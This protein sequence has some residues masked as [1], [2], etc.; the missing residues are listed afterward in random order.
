MTP[1]ARVA[2]GLKGGRCNSD[3]IDNS[4]GV[5]TSDVEVNI[6]IALAPAVR[7]G[8][9]SAPKRL[10]LLKAMTD[11]VAELVLRNNYQQTL[12]ISL[13]QKRGL[14][15]LGNQIRLMGE[16]EERGLLDRE[17]ENIPTDSAL[18]A[19]AAG[20][21]GLTRSEIG[22]LLAFAKIALSNDLVGSAVPDDSYLGREL[23]RYFPEEMQKRHAAGIE[24][25]RLRREIIATQLANSLVN[26]GGPT[27][28]VAARD[29]SGASVAELTRAYAAVRDSFALQTLHAEIDALDAAISGR[30][31]LELY[32]TVQDVLVDRMSWFIRNI[33]P[34]AGLEDIVAHYS[35]AFDALADVLPALL[36]REQT[37][38][39]REL[40]QRLKSGGVPESLAQRITLLPQLAHAASVV[41][42]ADRTGRTLADAAKAYF[43]VSDRFGFA[44]IDR[45]TE[46]IVSGDY[47]E[48]LALKKARD[49]LETAHR[50][51]AQ[52]VIANG[53][54]GDV[55][56]WEAVVGERVAAT[57]E[58]V[59][60]ILSDR[61]PSMAKVTVAASLL[62]ELARG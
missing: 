54:G 4:A 55:A 11:E 38:A 39:M 12:A 17:V 18:E 8:K 6:K 34:T 51:L 52:H 26:R 42:I 19:R 10:A 53:S 33:D 35:A 44:R 2:Y 57:A 41:P 62:S 24:G 21:R 14:D 37:K 1:K 20:G 58:Q 5:N 49:S 23:F 29:R 43:A 50:D 60:K 61:R 25:H 15:N 22:T 31:Q 28:L 56:A 32:A 47:Y 9:L 46:E 16:L 40:E 59:E 36:A 48:G 13:E 30:L 7:T 27:L 45:M 3:A